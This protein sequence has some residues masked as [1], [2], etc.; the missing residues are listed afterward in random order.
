MQK[1]Q[2]RAW[3]KCA[4]GDVESQPRSAS[5]S[6]LP[7]SRKA[8]A[9]ESVIHAVAGALADAGVELNVGRH[10]DICAHVEVVAG[11]GIAGARVLDHEPFVEGSH[12]LCPLREEAKRLMP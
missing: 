7:A 12:A 3:T 6:R 8:G 5:A 2:L 1:K 9:G 4:L 11:T 10:V